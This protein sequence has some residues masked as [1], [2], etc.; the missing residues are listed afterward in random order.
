M[1]RKE[2]KKVFEQMLV[3]YKWEDLLGTEYEKDLILFLGKKQYKVF[4]KN[5]KYFGMEKAWRPLGDKK[6][7]KGWFYRGVRIVKMKKPKK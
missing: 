1:K 5:K 7:V 3:D 4:M 2:M 6:K